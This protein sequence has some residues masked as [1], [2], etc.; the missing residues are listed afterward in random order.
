MA[1]GIGS[2]E[3][4]PGLGQPDERGGRFCPDHHAAGRFSGCDSAVERR[5]SVG[6]IASERLRTRV[7]MIPRQTAQIGER[8]GRLWIRTANERSLGCRERGC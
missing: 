3:R 7:R 8:A 4:A 2:G 6:Q 5:D 1:F